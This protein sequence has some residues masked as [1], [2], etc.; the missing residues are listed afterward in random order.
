MNLILTLY[1]GLSTDRP[2]SYSTLATSLGS[3]IMNGTQPFE[4][5]TYSNNTI[6]LDWFHGMSAYVWELGLYNLRRIIPYDG[7]QLTMNAPTIFCD[8][9]HPNCMDPSK[10][11]QPEPEAVLSE[12]RKLEV[13][14]DPVDPIDATWYL[15]YGPD[16][17]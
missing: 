13:S 8:G 16:K 17:M 6:F 15:S 14:D 9:G 3:V 5:L 1:G 11:P 4:A 2:N 7:L 10:P 12:R